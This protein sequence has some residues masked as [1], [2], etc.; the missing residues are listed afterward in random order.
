VPSKL[1]GKVFAT[2]KCPTSVDKFTF[3]TNQNLILNPFDLVKVE[4]VNGSHSYGMIEDIYVGNSNYIAGP[5]LQR[6]VNLRPSRCIIKCHG[7][8]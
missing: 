8:K 6:D 3:W 7:N 2:E 4:H 5:S 1:I